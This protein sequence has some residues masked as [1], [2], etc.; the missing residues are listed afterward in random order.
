M[1]ATLLSIAC[2]LAAGIAVASVHAAITN[3]DSNDEQP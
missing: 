2:L 1:M 3:E